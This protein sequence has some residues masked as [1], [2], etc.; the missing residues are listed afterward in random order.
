MGGLAELGVPAGSP[1]VEV[2]GVAL[3][4]SR[5]G[6]GHPVV[7]LHA[8]GHGGRD[9]EAF[10]D[11]MSARFEVIVVDWPGQGRSGPDREPASAARYADLL[12]PLL[13]TLGVTRPII[14]GNSIGGAAAIIHASREEVA[15]LVLCDPGGLFEPD[16]TV[17]RIVRVFIS[18]FKAGARGAWWYRPLFALYYRQV[19]PSPA[20]APQR[21][22]MVALAH[23]IAP[24]LVQSWTSF[25]QQDADIRELAAGLTAPVWFAWAKDDKVAQFSRSEPTI[26]AIKTATV[27]LFPGGH[28]PFLEQ[29]RAFVEGFEAFV[30]AND[31]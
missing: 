14:V 15:G 22:R 17:Q 20:A 1:M 11:A 29:P 13:R 27:T 7:C 21:R 5:R 9:F 30:A 31:L 19:L 23:E 6:R 26:R 28:A 18:F 10:V 24:I 2:D 12:G 16:A 3:A 4:V 25:S 8:T